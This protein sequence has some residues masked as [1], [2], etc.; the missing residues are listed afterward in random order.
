MIFVDF[1][2]GT[3]RRPR[4]PRTSKAR[5]WRP[6]AVLLGPARARR[7]PLH[8]VLQRALSARRG[9]HAEVVPDA[10][11]NEHRVGHEPHRAGR[12]RSSRPTCARRSGSPTPEVDF[13]P[14]SIVYVMPPRNAPGIEFSAELNFYQEP[15]RPDGKV[16][17]NGVTSGKDIF[18]W[19]RAI[20][21]HET[22]HDISFPEYTTAARARRTSESAAGTRWATPLGQAPDNMAWNKWKVGWIDDHR[23][24]L[25]RLRRHRR[26]ARSRADRARPPTAARQR[27]SSCGPGAVDGA[28]GRVAQAGRRRRD[29]DDHARAAPAC[30]T[31]A[32]SSTR[33]MSLKLNSYG[34]IRVGRPGCRARGQG[35]ARAISTSGR[36]AR[37]RATGR[38][39]Y[40]EA[41]P[42]R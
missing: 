6:A 4:P 2:E 1:P 20:I 11:E 21:D 29:Q 32:C 34:S 16:I 8:E 23:H 41:A 27:P 13:S 14:Y 12:S 38:S 3:P 36:W 40:E 22:G 30:A 19:G 42:A 10:Q 33:S 28:G 26:R 9:P 15:L 18:S 17:R 25:R 31:G 35:A 37:A 39:H 24:R 5:N 7:R